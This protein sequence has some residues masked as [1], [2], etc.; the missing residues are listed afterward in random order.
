VAVNRRAE[1]AAQS[2][3]EALA[4][5][6]KPAAGQALPRAAEPANVELTPAIER[7]IV[8]YVRAGGFPHVAAV[9]AGVPRELFDEWMQNGAQADSKFRS[10]YLAVLQAQAQARL[11]A[12]T[13]ALEEKPMDWLKCGPGRDTADSPGWTA[14][15]RASQRS[16]N[17]S[18]DLFRHPELQGLFAAVL[19][20]LTPFPEARAVVA[21][22]F[23]GPGGG[24]GVT[25]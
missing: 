3:N 18:T 14:A 17:A 2:E 5:H 15:A 24:D 19:D 8:A 16:G 11:A 23:F 1:Q 12:E 9:A 4:D 22:A 21:E 10:F 7:S 25:E 13:K 20:L 6:T